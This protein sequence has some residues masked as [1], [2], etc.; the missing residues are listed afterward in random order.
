MDYVKFNPP[1]S[2]IKFGGVL[3]DKNSLFQVYSRYFK[4]TVR[5]RVYTCSIL[6]FLKKPLDISSVYHL[7]AISFER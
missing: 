1:T 2:I 3:K 7:T 4:Y 6:E 5:L